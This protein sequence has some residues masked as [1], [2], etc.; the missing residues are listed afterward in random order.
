MATGK[1]QA[2][3]GC[4]R[5]L[6]SYMFGCGV[7]KQRSCMDPPVIEV[8]CDADA[9]AIP[10]NASHIN[11]AA[12]ADS[13]AAADAAA[14]R[15]QPGSMWDP[16]AG[17]ATSRP[18]VPSACCWPDTPCLLCGSP[19][20]L[21]DSWWAP[22]AR[23]GWA[24]AAGAYKGRAEPREGHSREV[25]ELFMAEIRQGRTPA[26]RGAMWPDAIAAQ[27][28]AGDAAE[29]LWDPAAPSEPECG[30]VLILPGGRG[31]AQFWPDMPCLSCGCPWWMG[32][33][34]DAPCARCGWAQAYTAYDQYYDQQPLPEYRETYDRF[35]AQIEQGHTPEWGGS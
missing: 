13:P 18:P 2:P 32:E 6:L 15:Q 8:Q 17:Y 9:A 4:V 5:R 1:Q 28:A 14:A 7:T 35:R 12:E 3:N 27:E 22:C 24:Q 21:G 19:W 20:W 33:G 31:A 16:P 34:W 25:Y 30:P 23:C 26:W 29:R 11:S 10:I